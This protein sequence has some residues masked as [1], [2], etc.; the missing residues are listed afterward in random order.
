[1]PAPSIVAAEP[2]PPALAKEAVKHLRAYPLYAALQAD[3][4]SVVARDK[5]ARRR[6]EDARPSVV[7][8][9]LATGGRLVSV[10]AEGSVEGDGCGVD[11][12]AH[13]WLLFRIDEN[14]V[15]TLANRPDAEKAIVPAALVDVDGDGKPALLFRSAFDHAF[16]SGSGQPEMLD[17]GLVRMQGG[18]YDEPEGLALFSH[19]CPC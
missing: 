18:L 3:Y 12:D 8:L 13:L 19:V 6:W 7:T 5:T 10:T 16:V 17:V 2:A 15:W 11:F 1:L 14:G 4:A 9:P